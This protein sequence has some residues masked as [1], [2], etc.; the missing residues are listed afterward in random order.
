MQFASVTQSDGTQT[1]GEASVFL[2]ADQTHGEFVPG[3]ST[4]NPGR[5]NPKDG[6]A[7]TTYEAVWPN[8]GE[9]T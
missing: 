2:L 8:L 3:R 1:M 9:E 4:Q 5:R 7:L 6:S